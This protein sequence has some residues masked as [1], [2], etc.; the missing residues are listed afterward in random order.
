[1]Y[2][3][4]IKKYIENIT[5]ND[6]LVFAHNQNINLTNEEVDLF[7]VNIKE[8]WELILYQNPNNLFESLKTK[9]QPDTYQKMIELYHYFKEKYKNYL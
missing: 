9:L 1:M 3:F 8:H 2:Q 4:F 6:I 5:K 7:Y